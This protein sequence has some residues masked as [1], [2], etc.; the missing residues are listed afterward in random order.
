MR[1]RIYLLLRIGFALFFLLEVGG[2]CAEKWISF[3]KSEKGDEYYYDEGSIK[4]VAKKVVQVWRKK[5]LS[6]V[7]RADYAKMDRKF[8]SLDNIKALVELDCKKK[9]LKT[10]SVEYYDDKGDLLQ[11]F[12]DPDSGRRVVRP[13]SRS[14]M[15][16]NTVCSK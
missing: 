1:Q 2:Y 16:L 4:E 13:A 9:T 8:N 6:A 15:L 10:I 12:S 14:E 7:S 3:A 5:R 11:S